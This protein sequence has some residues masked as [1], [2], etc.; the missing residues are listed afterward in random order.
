MARFVADMPTGKPDD[1][2]QFIVQDYL[3]KEGFKQILY[4][5][6]EQV[7]K[8]GNG[9]LT[10][11]Q[12]I[13]VLTN[14]GNVHLEAWMRYVILPGV[15]VGEMDLSGGWGFAVKALLKNRVDALARLLYQPIPAPSPAVVPQVVDGAP[16]QG[17]DPGSAAYGQPVQNNMQPPV[18]NQPVQPPYAGAPAANPYAM[19]DGTLPTA[20]PGYQPVPV[21]VH[22]PTNKAVVSLIMGLVSVLG[23]FVPIAG[24]VAGIIGIVFGLSGRKSTAKVMAIIGLVLS[25]VFLIV[26]LVNWGCGIYLAFMD[27]I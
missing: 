19:P 5:K 14:Q 12:Y 2:V 24:V 25:V 9:L 4:K 13:K 22:N 27:I 17:T 26:S 20:Y 1:M 15:Y 21:A 11:P 10:A 3:T 7:W 8:K 18:P 16:V 23:C 6:T